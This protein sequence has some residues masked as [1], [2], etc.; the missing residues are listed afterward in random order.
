[1]GY[2]WGMVEDK[3]GGYK[4]GKHRPLIQTDEQRKN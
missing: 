3:I 2:L 4:H 1:M